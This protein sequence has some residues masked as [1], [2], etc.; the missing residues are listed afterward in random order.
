MRSTHI[1]QHLDLGTDPFDLGVILRLQMGENGI[2]IMASITPDCE[3]PA[4]KES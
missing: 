2:G 1:L 3:L 4:R